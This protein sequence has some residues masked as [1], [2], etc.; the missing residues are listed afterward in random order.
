MPLYQFGRYQIKSKIKRG[1]MA[2]VFHA[3]DP[4]F[5]RDVALKVLP[6]ELSQYPNFRARFEREAQ[7]IAGLEHPAIVPVYDFGN[8]GNLP[9]L[10]MQYLNG[11]TL[12]NRLESG[13]ISFPETTRILTY[14]A[15]ALDYVH[16]QGIIHRDLKPSNIL[17]DQHNNPFITDFGIV[18]LAKKDKSLTSTGMVIG[19]PL[20]MSPEQARGEPTIDER[21]DIYAMGVIIFHMLAGQLPFQANT[22]MGIALKHITDP[23]PDIL[24]IKPNLPPDCQAIID[25]VMHKEPDQRYN[26][27]TELSTALTTIIN[28]PKSKSTVEPLAPPPSTPIADETAFSPPPTIQPQNSRDLALQH[29]YNMEDPAKYIFARSDLLSMGIKA[30]KPLTKTLLNGNKTSIRSNSA[31]ILKEICSNYELKSLTRA[32]TIKTLS[33]ALSDPEIPVRYCALT[34]LTVFK[35]KQLESAVEPVS[36]LL[37]DENENIRQQAQQVLKHIGSKHAKAVLKVKTV[38]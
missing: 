37:L 31:T 8:E 6:P 17:F 9:F 16:R 20:Y 3:F 35:S 26:T 5:K 1:G 28:K 36:Q 23:V 12:T 38:R 34:A 4:R 2:A 15:P 30:I 19:T 22:P 32:R 18:K 14:L 33:K 25:C 21:S 7:T 29:I 11:G 24:A 27:T 10:V 13:A